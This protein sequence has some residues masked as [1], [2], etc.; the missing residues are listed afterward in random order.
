M[1]AEVY[2]DNFEL[3]N[4]PDVSITIVNQDK[5]S[6]P[7]TFSKTDK[8]YSLTAGIFAPGDYHYK[9][10]VKIGEKLY[11]ADGD[12][13]VNALQVEQNETVADHQMLNTLS[14]KTGG[15][16]FYPSQLSELSALLQSHNDIKTVS[17]SQMKLIDLVNLKAIFF[18]LLVMLSME[19]FFRKRSGGY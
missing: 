13:S 17:Y 4:A 5:K 11:T 8:A 10:Q 15:Q 2:N 3:I 7:F 14:Q 6:F 9:A 18:L 12:F 1:D 16:L 19:W